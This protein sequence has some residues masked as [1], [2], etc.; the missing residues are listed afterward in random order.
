MG[1][2]TSHTLRTLPAITLA[3]VLALAVNGDR[4]HAL[5]FTVNSTGDGADV[6]TL[7]GVCADAGGACTLRAAIQQANFSPGPDTIS[8]AII[9]GVQTISPA[10]NYDFISDAL[11]IDGTTQP[12]FA[13]TPLIRLN[14][15]GSAL[16]GL[17]IDSD[18]VTIR[19]LAINRF[20]T[21]LEVESGQ[22]IN[23]VGNY[24]G[25]APDGSGSGN[26]NAGVLVHADGGS[27]TQNHI[28]GTAT[29]DRNVISA[30]GVGVVIQGD[31]MQLAGNY[32]GTDPSGS[33]PLPNGLGVVINVA[34]CDALDAPSGSP[35]VISGNTG[36]GVLVN[37]FSFGTTGIR[38]NLIG[39]A[40]DGVSALGNGGHG[41]NVQNAEVSLDANTIAFN[42]GDGV[43]ACATTGRVTL[44]SGEMYSNAGLGI[45]LND[46]GVTPNDDL[47]G[48]S[49][50]NGLQNYP[51]LISATNSGSTT[52][53]TGTLNTSAATT[54]FLVFYENTECDPSGF[55]EARE[56]V[57]VVPVAPGTT[58]GAGNLSFSKSTTQLFVGEWVTATA[59]T[60]DG[61]SEFSNCIP[62]CSANSLSWTVPPNDSDCDGF[63]D[64]APTGPPLGR[65]DE[66][67]VGTVATDP[68]AGTDTPNDEELP[69][70]WPVDLND[71]QQVTGPDLLALGPVFGA[72]SPNPPYDSRYDLS[73]DG[74]ITGP[75]LL[76]FGDFF[77]DRCA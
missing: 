15:N 13:G 22:L 39:N 26:H 19:G 31:Y 6:T 59:T 40:A 51:L 8:F 77:G 44:V 20:S 21:G 72:M 63:P 35:N 71:S 3:V 49:G 53:I 58:D 46:D 16:T 25:V 32:I 54:V 11:T 30:N 66:G 18:S 47:D 24:I 5:S 60:A 61:Q 2:L 34:C 4:A 76:K 43:C 73:G 52:T 27:A 45:D 64:T 14:G 28:G 1:R 29:G 55:G 69:D 36:G 12:G 10:T 62:V 68:C 74:K 23:I 70:V 56:A 41:V 7:D 75:D 50:P 48:D 33:S 42:G 67:F 17:V 57:A 9:S 37:M 38:G 65:A